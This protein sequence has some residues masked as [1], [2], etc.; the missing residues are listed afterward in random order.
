MFYGDAT[1]PGFRRRGVQAALIGSR[2]RQATLSGSKW[3]IACAL[4]GT[5]SQRNYERAGFRV[6]YTKTMLVRDGL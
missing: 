5:A 1:L 6:A 2:L 3:A 4:P